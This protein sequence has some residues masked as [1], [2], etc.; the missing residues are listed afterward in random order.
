MSVVNDVLKNLNER[1]ARELSF[2]AMP[3]SYEEKKGQPWL[4]WVAIACIF[5][6]TVYLS[7]K[8]WQQDQIRYLALNVPS[9]VFLIPSENKTVDN[10]KVESV[11]KGEDEDKPIEKTLSRNESTRVVATKVEAS[12]KPVATKTAQ[13]Q[14][15]EQAVIA[16]QEG[17][18][19]T[20]KKLLNQTS[21][22]I[23]DDLKLRIMVKDD[24]VAVWPYIKQN[25]PDFQKDVSLLALAAQGLQRSGQH[26]MAI[27]FY[28]QLVRLEPKDAKWR[29]ALAISLEA[30]GDDQAAKQLYQIALSMPNLPAPLAQFSQKRLTLLN[31]K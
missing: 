28:Q 27:G 10:K 2:Q 16:V 30:K 17:D 11:A 4:L 13:T 21:D 26:D 14:A 1:H 19:Q 24:P 29:A 5:A 31:G 20:A 22:Y 6:V 8:M 25:F 9:D 18:T 3:Y 12:A 23:R 15:T 7:I